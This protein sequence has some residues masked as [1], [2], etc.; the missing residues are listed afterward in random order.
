MNN[1]LRNFELNYQ[2]FH[3]RKHISSTI[4]KTIEKKLKKILNINKLLKISLNIFTT[5][6]FIANYGF[7]KSA[8]DFY[9]LYI[10]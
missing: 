9:S 8:W 7:S 1:C 2:D 10:F 3:P 5:S 6:L 4:Y